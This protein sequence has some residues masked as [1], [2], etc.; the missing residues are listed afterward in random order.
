MWLEADWY[1]RLGAVFLTGCSFSEDSED[2]ALI[3]AFAYQSP[4]CRGRR[5]YRD[6]RSGFSRSSSAGPPRALY[7]RKNHRVGPPRSHD[8]A[9]WLN[10]RRFF[11]DMWWSGG[12]TWGGWRWFRWSS[13][14][15]SPGLSGRAGMNWTSGCSGSQG[16]VQHIFY[17][18][19]LKII[20]YFSK[21]LSVFVLIISILFS[22]ISLYFY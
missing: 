12:G 6:D 11:D 1:V 5:Q 3:H 22:R 13:G 19:F 8:A 18:Y 21:Y 10:Q 4:W 20:L 2:S 17:L 14:S 16:Q 9:C 7:L 15:W